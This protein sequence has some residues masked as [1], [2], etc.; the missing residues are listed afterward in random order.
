MTNSRRI[1]T[2]RRWEQ[3]LAFRD[4]TD[5]AA[6]AGDHISD[7]GSFDRDHDDVMRT[8]DRIVGDFGRLITVLAQTIDVTRGP[9][10]SSIECLSNTKRLAERGLELSR[11]L[12]ALTRKSGDCGS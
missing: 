4:V 12:S 1:S 10:D 11:H 9:D 3:P 7:P 5:R 2:N 8:V 6:S